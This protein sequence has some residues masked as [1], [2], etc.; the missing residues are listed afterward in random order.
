MILHVRIHLQAL[1]YLKIV[2]KEKYYSKSIYTGFEDQKGFFRGG[3]LKFSDHVS[4]TK[5]LIH[6]SLFKEGSTHF[7]TEDN[8]E[9]EKML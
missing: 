9:I 8:S 3:K 5:F 1:K 2:H 6:A 4:S 7:S